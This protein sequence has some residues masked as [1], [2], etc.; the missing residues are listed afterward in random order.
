[1]IGLGYATDVVVVTEEDVEKYRD[2]EGYVIRPALT[3][4]RLVYAA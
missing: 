2:A 3:E 1:M 4:G